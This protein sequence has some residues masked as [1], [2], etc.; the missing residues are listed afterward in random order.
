MWRRQPGLKG[1][2]E[3]KRCGEFLIQVRAD[4]CWL[5]CSSSVA[6]GVRFP[7]CE[8]L[9]RRFGPDCKVKNKSCSLASEDRPRL[10]GCCV[11][12]GARDASSLQA[13]LSVKEVFT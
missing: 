11:V 9:E 13:Y 7:E 3:W 4:L 8:K 5:R 12:A 2:V 10:P 6:N 1:R